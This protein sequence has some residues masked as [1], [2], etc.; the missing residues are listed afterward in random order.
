MVSTGFHIYYRCIPIDPIG[1]IHLHMYS[2]HMYTHICI[3]IFIYLYI[4]TY[5]CMYTYR[6]TKLEAS[7]LRKLH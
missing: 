2:V 4:Y 5:V 6:L 3:Y 7:L 1:P